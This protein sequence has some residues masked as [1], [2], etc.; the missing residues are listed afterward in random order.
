M[1]QVIYIYICSSPERKSESW[2][3]GWAFIHSADLC[4]ST[5]LDA[6]RRLQGRRVGQSIGALSYGDLDLSLTGSLC[7]FRFYPLRVALLAAIYSFGLY[8][9]WVFMSS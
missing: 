2:F 1:W 3:S 7:R 4:V 6:R 5:V 8:K 9:W